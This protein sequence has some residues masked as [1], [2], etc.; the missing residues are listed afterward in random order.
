MSTVFI[1]ECG[2]TGQ[3]LLDTEQPIFTLASLK[4]SE[5][6][7][8]ELKSNFFRNIQLREL[9]YSVLK[10]RPKQQEM[11]LEFI[12]ELSKKS[13]LVKFAFAHKQFVLVS[14]MVEMLV[15]PVCYGEGIDLYDK[16]ANIGLANGLFYALPVFGG[17]E[18]FNDLL[19]AFQ[20]MIRSRTKESYQIFF[21]MVF[22]EG[23]SE[24]LNE[25][26][27]F[28]RL[29]HIKFGYELL[30][31]KDHLDVAVSLT[32]VLMS[33]WRK[34]VHDD[35]ILIHDRSSAM[36]KQKKIWDAIVA[37]NL[38]PIE[39][40]YDRRK[41]QFPISVVQT[42]PED[43]KSWAGLQLVDILAGALTHCAR[44]LTEGKSDK[45]VFGKRL[46]DLI[47]DTFDCFPILP[48]PNFTPEQLGTTGNNAVSPHDYLTSIFM[49][50]PE[51][52]KDENT[53]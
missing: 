24:D 50:N 23:Y 34:D 22:A 10:R 20:K 12:R 39:V 6:D 17:I 16:G 41:T 45:D 2:Y 43:S 11:I 4:L 7:C 35:L 47:G 33:L 18:L 29:S 48:Q 19:K 21:N 52:L 9:K 31:T 25:L 40:G 36:A 38:G 37:P 32:L 13:D 1:D 14:K 53:Y 28:F 30:E 15:E 8:Q 49:K 44:W 26:L 51:I 5:E 27:D 42:R 46:T 3:N